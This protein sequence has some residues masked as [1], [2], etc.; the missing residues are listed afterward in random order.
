MYN[1]DNERVPFVKCI[2][3][4]ICRQ[5][6]QLARKVRTKLDPLSC[7]KKR[8]SITKLVSSSNY[9]FLGITVDQGEGLFASLFCLKNY[10]SSSLTNLQSLEQKATQ[11]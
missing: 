7:K 3:E 4:S 5:M 11:L 9:P 8:E 1:Q 10:L 6:L 2:R